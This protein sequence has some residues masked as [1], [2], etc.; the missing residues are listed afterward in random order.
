MKQIQFS[1]NA[2]Q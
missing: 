1:N 2:A